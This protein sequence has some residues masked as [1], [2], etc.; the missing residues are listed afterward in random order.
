MAASSLGISSPSP[1]IR[2]AFFEAGAHE[3]HSAPF[4]TQTQNGQQC[5]SSQHDQKHQQH[6]QTESLCNLTQQAFDDDA[7]AQSRSPPLDGTL[8]RGSFSSVREDE[9]GHAQS[10]T[11]SKTSAFTYAVE[12]ALVDS[13]NSSASSSPIPSRPAVR[14]PPTLSSPTL[15]PPTTNC[16]SLF[17]ED[18]GLHRSASGIAVNTNTNKIDAAGTMWQPTD[19]FRGWKQINLRG[20][21]ASRSFSDLQLLNMMWN[22][23]SIPAVEDASAKPGAGHSRLEI[24]P[25]ELLGAIIDL[26]YV[27]TPTKGLTKRNGD[28]I[29]V[30][31]TSHTLHVATMH[32]LYR[33]ITIPHSKIFRK[34]LTAIQRDPFLGTIVQRLDF[35]HFNPNMLF[36]TGG[37]RS[38][39]Q[40]LTKDT[41]LQCLELTPNV[42]E[43][44]AQEHILEDLS[45]QV[46]NKLFF[47]LEKLQAVDFAGCSNRAFKL[48][49]DEVLQDSEKWTKALS[50]KRMSFHKCMILPPVVYE[51]VFPCL[52]RLTHLDVT[53]CRVTDR[54]L[55]L[56]P[57]TARIAHLNLSKCAQLTADCV[58]QFIEKHPSVRE[59]LVVLNVATDAT[60]HQMFNEDQVSKLL[61]ILPPTLKSL[62]L[63]GSRM[64]PQH[65]KQ[66]KSVVAQIEELGIGRG[67]DIR[68]VGQLIFPEKKK[69]DQSQDR[70]SAAWDIGSD[71]GDSDDKSDLVGIGHSLRYIDVS[72]MYSTT[73]LDYLFDKNCRLLDS[74][75]YPLQVI[76]VSENVAKRMRASYKAVRSHGW[77]ISE[78]GARC[79]LVRRNEWQTKSM[80][81]EEAFR[82]WKMGATYW[83]TRKIPVADCEVGGMYGSFMFARK[84]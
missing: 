18:K 56:I 29:A 28:L 58:L 59:T 53:G 26:L 63:K 17:P 55:M 43:F 76:E 4:S 48:V 47:G 69:V 23:P 1:S 66:L 33:K 61:T 60:S 83:G 31:N 38:Q 46:V 44:L 10:F 25:I 54:A 32:T 42:R 82:W 35:N 72:D 8:S 19:T 22:L 6:Q 41:L 40:N 64:G 13:P 16:A 7:A 15:A 21:Y 78:E 67:V 51:T 65:I 68:Q 20:K 50:I 70:G 77:A 11:S 84:I 81:H 75:S 2:S 34:F 14:P 52:D 71:S 45:A 57:Q 5:L 80:R 74:V 9:L 39:A 24:L 79:W 49:W 12:S 27:E 36:S 30:L 37:E 73:D 62:N 3:R